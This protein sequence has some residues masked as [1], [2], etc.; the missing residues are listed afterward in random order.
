MPTST[1]SPS[2]PC[3]LHTPVTGNGLPEADVQ[4]TFVH[5][6]LCTHSP[7]AWNASPCPFS[8]STIKAWLKCP[9]SSGTSTGLGRGNSSGDGLLAVNAIT[10]IPSWEATN[11]RGSKQ[12]I[13]HLLALC[14]RQKGPPLPVPPFPKLW[15]G[16]IILSSSQV[17]Y[18]E[19]GLAK[20]I[21]L[22]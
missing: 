18:P 2:F 17:E 5:P 13:N 7:S 16:V 20:E 3:S 21:I 1:A 6:G 12:K 11:V 19:Q 10:D 8:L 15:K 14:L 22:E 9:F 4:H